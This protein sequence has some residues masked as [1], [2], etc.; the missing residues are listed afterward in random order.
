MTELDR[1]CREQERKINERTREAYN[2]GELLLDE[3]YFISQSAIKRG[4]QNVRSLAV[5]LGYALLA[6][7]LGYALIVG[8]FSQGGR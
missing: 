6:G 4:E 1:I 2:R 8:I 5:I 3:R 7:L